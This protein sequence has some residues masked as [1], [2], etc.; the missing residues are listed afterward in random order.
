MNKNNIN[1][2]IDYVIQIY[3]DKYNCSIEKATNIVND[4]SSIELLKLNPDYVLH[5]NLEY[6]AKEIRREA[7]K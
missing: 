5:Y 2:A 4:S 7:L 6:W 1:K 3:S